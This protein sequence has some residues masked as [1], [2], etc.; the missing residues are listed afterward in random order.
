MDSNQPDTSNASPSL[1]VGGAIPTGATIGSPVQNAGLQVGAPIPQGA[2]VGQPSPKQSSLMINSGDPAL[3]KIGKAIGGVFAGGGESLAGTVAGAGDIASKLG[4]AHVVPGL[5]QADIDK[6]NAFLHHLAGDDETQSLAEKIGQGGETIA[7]FI[8]GDEAL[9]AVPYVKRLETA[10]KATKVIQGAP[11]L[12]QVMQIGAKVMKLAALHGAEA[13]VVQGVQTGVKTGGDVEQAAKEGAETGVTGG[14]L[15]TGVQGLGSLAEWAGNTATKVKDLAKIAATGK[16]TQEIADELSS[17]LKQAEVQRGADFESGINKIK[18]DLAG[19]TVDRQDSPMMIQAKKSLANPIPED[20]PTTKL[21]KEISGD[22]LDAK[23]K[24]LLQ[25]SALGGKP[26]QGVGPVIGETSNAGEIPDM[27]VT[28]HDPYTIDNLIQ[29]RQ[30][31]REAASGYDYR[32]PNAYALRRMNDAVD[33]TIE[34]MASNVGKPDV[35][36]NY[37]K[38]RVDYKANL[39]AFKDPVI[40]N[41]RDAKPNDAAKAFIG[42]VNSDSTLPSAGRTNYNIDLLKNA[43]GPDGVKAFGH[44]VFKN[45]LKDSVEKGRI[46]PG[47]F[48]ESWNRIDD[49]TKENLFDINSAQ[50]GLNQ[51]AKDAEAGAKL[52]LLSKFGLVSGVGAAG[53]GLGAAGAPLLHMGMGV[54]T[55]LGLIVAEGGGIAVGR[56]FLNEIADHPNTWTMYQKAGQVA[57]NSS[58]RTAKVAAAAGTDLLNSK[59]KVM[60]GATDSLGGK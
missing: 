22:K 23:T 19:Q 51:L 9:K 3:E 8:L 5:S 17:R 7:E 37:Q 53:A 28:P 40:R 15:D 25:D 59:K 16:G 43:I 39:D 57:A 6:G 13:G 27:A 58:G 11:K 55:M 21:A 49:Y 12:A 26:V 29:I 14:I 42:V 4:V 10:L 24:A 32:D 48:A 1:T 34:K 54:G 36:S 46:N 45:M 41:L 35:L 20:D 60:Q 31:I 18:K 44:D 2:T 47:K 38:L 30:A 33:D 52:Q 56:S 50:N